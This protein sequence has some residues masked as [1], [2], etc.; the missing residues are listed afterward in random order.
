MT[1]I[2]PVS[3][4]PEISSAPSVGVGSGGSERNPFHSET[5]SAI[6]RAATPRTPKIAAPGTAPGSQRD[7]RPESEQ[8]Q[9]WFRPS[10]V[11][12]GDQCFRIRLD[13]TRVTQSDHS[14]EDADP[15]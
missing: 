2:I 14:E 1:A 8:G 12:H 4:A 11:A 7:D 5:P 9:N 3:N 13:N 6:P 10:W 15:R